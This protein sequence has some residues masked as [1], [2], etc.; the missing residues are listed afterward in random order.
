[1]KV[2]L[3]AAALCGLAFV[4]AADA[5]ILLTVHKVDTVTPDPV[6]YPNAVDVY[7]VDI[8]TDQGSISSL[9][10][11]FTH[12]K[13]VNAL[14][15][16]TFQV[17]AGF[18]STPHG[19]IPETFFVIPPGSNALAINV[20]DDGDQTKLSADYT[21]QNNSVFKLVPDHTNTTVAVLVVDAGAPNPADTSGFVVGEAVGNSV[22]QIGELNPEFD[23]IYAGM[24]EPTSLAL[25]TVGGLALIRRR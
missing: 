11:D 22:I 17:G 6:F 4:A 16:T 3:H 14:P 9:S 18:F 25:L 10:L 19:P 12:P 23:V 5:A 8:F 24:P 13:L 7:H 1:M 20:L 21:V 15:G 2:H